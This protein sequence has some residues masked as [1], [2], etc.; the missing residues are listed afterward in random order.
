VFGVFTSREAAYRKFVEVGGTDQSHH[1]FD[2]MDYVRG[3]HYAEVSNQIHA[4]Y[5]EGELV[6]NN[7]QRA[8]KIIGYMVYRMISG[9]PYE[10]GG[11]E[12]SSV[13][14][15]PGHVGVEGF[16]ADGE[17]ETIFITIV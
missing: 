15:E 14:P 4:L 16:D 6:G 2:G 8:D 3:D 5:S 11:V 9:G 12:L 13:F 17:T 1:L 10:G 7:G